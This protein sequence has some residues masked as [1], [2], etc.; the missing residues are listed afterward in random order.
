MPGQ[1]TRKVNEN[2]KQVLKEEET[3]LHNGPLQSMFKFCV[4]VSMRKSPPHSNSG[5]FLFLFYVFSDLSFSLPPSRA[6]RRSAAAV[7]TDKKKKKKHQYNKP[8]VQLF[9][10]YAHTVRNRGTTLKL[11]QEKRKNQR[12]ARNNK[13]PKK[14]KNYSD[15]S[16]KKLIR[17][18][19]II[20]DVW[21][22]ERTYCP[23]TTPSSPA[24]VH[25]ELF[26]TTTE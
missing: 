12:T 21:Y 25:V 19:P 4:R 2:F 5:N 9:N 1:G 6:A 8:T 15:E 10:S 14:T 11:K 18:R 20:N 22:V 17:R 23:D 26:L 3:R 7:S 16:K 24:G 13:I